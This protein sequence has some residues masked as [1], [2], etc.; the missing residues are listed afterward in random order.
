LVVRERLRVAFG[1][2]DAL[3]DNRTE[4]RGKGLAGLDEESSFWSL[5]WS[6]GREVLRELDGLVTDDNGGGGSSNGLARVRELV[7]GNGG[8]SMPG[9]G[10]PLGRGEVEN[11][12]PLPDAWCSSCSEPRGLGA[13]LSTGGVVGCRARD[14]EGD[15]GGGGKELPCARTWT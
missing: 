9:S 14:T 8:G 11:M 1:E 3:G 12:L 2:M 4:C 5:S 13:A 10:T 6:S 15:S 7:F